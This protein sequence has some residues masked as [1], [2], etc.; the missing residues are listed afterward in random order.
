[1]LDYRGSCPDSKA[2][3]ARPLESNALLGNGAHDQQ[4][5]TN[6]TN[7]AVFFLL[8]KVKIS[9][10]LGNVPFSF[11]LFEVKAEGQVL[12]AT[13]QCLLLLI[14]VEAAA[15]GRV[16]QATLQSHLLRVLVE[17]RTTRQALQATR[18]CHHS[19]PA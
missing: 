9:T 4:A 12:Q 6:D 8:E 16:L 15:E 10:P 19:I 18:H 14:L 17:V 1:M 2:H 5:H 13:W 7:A 3:A 11:V